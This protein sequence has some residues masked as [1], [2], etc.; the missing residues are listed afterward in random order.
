M[1]ARFTKTHPL[2]SAKAGAADEDLL[3]LPLRVCDKDDAAGG[4]RPGHRVPLSGPHLPEDLQPTKPEPRQSTMPFLNPAARVLA[5][6]T[7]GGPGSVAARFGEAEAEEILERPQEHAEN[8]AP[9]L[10][11][12]ANRLGWSVRDAALIAVIRGP[13]SFTGLRVGVSLAKALAW[14]GEAT[15]VGLSTAEVIAEAV[16]ARGPSPADRHEGEAAPLHVVFDA[17]RGEVAAFCVVRDE[18]ATSGWA[19]VAEPLE[20]I[21]AW[22]ERLPTGVRIAGPALASLAE[23]LGPFRRRRPDL[24]FCD[25]QAATPSLAAIA[26]RLAIRRAASGSVDAAETLLPD[27]LRPS[28]AEEK[29]PGSPP[30]GGA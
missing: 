13:G 23:Q 11:R 25:Q 3:V 14:A 17:G 29:R 30:S 7:S 12:V 6:D 21:A 16:A 22:L 28:Y 8:L 24:I 18:H 1:I 26:A 5:I 2:A 9:A 15:L 4:R 10:E 20:P 19:V 27:Y